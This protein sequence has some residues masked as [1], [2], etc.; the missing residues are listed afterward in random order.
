[1]T[2]NE[3]RE[4]FLKY[5]E[6]KGH[7]R[8]KSA[9]LVP[10]NDPTL[11]FVNAGMVPFKNIF[12]GEEKRPDK[13][14]TTAQKCMRVSGKHN[15]LENVGRTARH[16]TF[17]EMLGNFS[18]GDYFKKD[19]IAFAWELLTK[20][21]G[22]PQDKLWVTVFRE[23]D[24]AEKIWHEDQGV[25]KERIFRL[26]EKDNFWAMGE[27]GPCGPCSEIHYQFADC[28]PY[29]PNRGKEWFLENGDAGRIMEV[30]NLVFM[31]YERSEG[32]KLTPLPKPSIDTGMGLERIAAVLQGKTSNYDTD[33]FTPLLSEVEKITGKKYEAETETGVSM[34]V[35]ADHIRATVFL[36]A[37]GVL[38]SN[39]GRGYV[40]RRIMRR[41]IRHGKL[42]GRTE[43][44][45][46][47]LTATLVKEMGAAYPEI[48]ASRETVE[49]VIRAE[50]ERFFETLEKGLKLLGEEIETHKK[51]GAGTLK[52]EVAFKLYDTYGFPL[53][54]TELIA[55]ENAMTV[56]QD[57]F[58]T[59]MTVQ[60]ERARA[61]WKGSGEAK[62]GEIY[63]ELASKHRT[64]FLGYDTLEA[65]AKI[66]A[67]L[68]NGEL[69]S[70]VAASR[71]GDCTVSCEI[72]FDQTPCYAEGG[73]QV[74]D[75][76]E[77]KSAET[78][79]GGV[80]D[81]RKVSGMFVH[82]VDVVSGTL[83]VGAIVQLKVHRPMRRQTMRNHSATHL[84]HAA[85]RKILGS[86]VRQAGSLVNDKLLRFD[87]SH[88]EA[89]PPERLRD[90]ENAVN[91]AILDNLPIAK[92]ELPYDAAIAKGAL[93]FFGDKYGDLVRVVSMGEY[94]VELCG[95]THLDS[96]AEIGFFRIV[97]EGSVAAGVRRIEAVTGEEAVRLAQEE[98][99]SLSQ[100][101]SALKT[102]S[103]EVPERI[104]KLKAQIKSLEKDV[105]KLKSQ[106]LRG[107]AGDLLKDAFEVNGVKAVAYR[108]EVDNPKG[109]QE[110]SDVILDKLKSGVCAVYAVIDGKVSLIVA[111]TKDL[112]AKHQANKILQPLAEL[113]GGRGGGKPDRAQAG[114]AD[115]GKLDQIAEKLRQALG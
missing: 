48:A 73:G 77:I 102:V 95:G 55:A 65:P 108:A 35:L 47:R 37:D 61:A 46:H 68:R 87:F 91:A 103:R 101:A 30:W 72:V 71:G 96:T 80:T 2:G 49:K 50:E 88:F 63:L 111:V 104:E 114:G 84:M 4:I 51:T 20:V 94:S 57:G 27:T 7:T 43:P 28:T 8:V 83:K 31:Q 29:D 76:A 17:F 9:P 24:D 107:G 70:E 89:I 59:A 15:D 67:I 14:A 99:D 105:E 115:A 74:G 11:Y 1:M 44:F 13:R 90:I 38:P 39:E 32:G 21:Y 79:I 109:L 23:D 92:E 66:L 62:V 41:A 10:Q 36:I 58:E 110:I 3:I 52:G 12:T 53:D 25:P 22:I 40:L 86:H 33:F 78:L 54:L 5:F 56:D 18:F 93:A 98:S 100:S 16:H 26:D 69:V 64:N 85:L 34:R 42:L 112:N 6:S 19:A 113:I 45:F 97:S 82:K 81:T 75:V 106:M 60:K